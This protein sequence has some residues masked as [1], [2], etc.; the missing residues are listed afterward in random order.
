MEAAIRS[1]P[2][3]WPV[4]LGVLLAFNLVQAIV[5]GGRWNW[6][7]VAVIA[8]ALAL[9]LWQNRKREPPPP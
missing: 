6:I 4:V 3:W 2:S 1:R 7:V 5:A 9:N 8:L